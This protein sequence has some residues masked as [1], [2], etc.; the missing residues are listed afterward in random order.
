MAVPRDRK[1]LL[2]L[3]GAHLAFST[4]AITSATAVSSY[5]GEGQIR[6]GGSRT[7]L[8]LDRRSVARMRI[9]TT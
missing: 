7:S 6:S 1:L 3:R 8:G 2:D 9:F 5:K 4:G